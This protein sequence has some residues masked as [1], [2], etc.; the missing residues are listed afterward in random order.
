ME[1]HEEMTQIDFDAGNWPANFKGYFKDVVV[2]L[3]YGVSIV[4]GAFV[5]FIAYKVLPHIDMSSLPEEQKL[6][7]SIGFWQSVYISLFVLMLYYWVIVPLRKIYRYRGFRQN[8]SRNI[9]KIIKSIIPAA[10]MLAIWFLVMSYGL[11]YVELLTQRKQP[12]YSV[13]NFGGVALLLISGAE[14]Q[15]VAMQLAYKS[16]NL[17]VPRKSPLAKLFAKLEKS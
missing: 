12:L 4:I 10:I 7:G 15:H 17:D 16:F 8:Y 5:F 9:L 3:Y 14:L 2:C 11:E 1:P 6:P 13:L